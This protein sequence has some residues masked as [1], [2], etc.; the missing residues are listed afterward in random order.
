MS[1]TCKDM[2][3]ANLERLFSDIIITEMEGMNKD[4]QLHWEVYTH[5]V[6]INEEKSQNNGTCHKD[7]R[8]EYV[9]V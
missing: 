4:H 5:C 8:E 3:S 1:P 9:T 2:L 7:T 6:K